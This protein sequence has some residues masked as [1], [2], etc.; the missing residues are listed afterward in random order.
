MQS[1]LSE[2]VESLLKKLSSVNANENIISF[3]FS[4]D[5]HL[6]TEIIQSLLIEHGHAAFIALPTKGSVVERLYVSTKRPSNMK[7]KI[8]REKNDEKK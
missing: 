7:Q 5:N 8:E 4:S 6:A 3:D 2:L 1:E